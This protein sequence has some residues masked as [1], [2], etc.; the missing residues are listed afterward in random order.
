M[1]NSLWTSSVLSLV[2]VLP[3]AAQ[4]EIVGGCGDTEC[5]VDEV[6]ISTGYDHGTGSL[7]TPVAPD[8]WWTLVDAPN[9]GL[10]LPSPA[11]VITP[12]V[13]WTTFTG[14]R[15][16]S[17]YDT[18]ALNLDNPTPNAP[19]S[20]ERCICVCDP[21][22]LNINFDLL[23][24]NVADVYF[25]NVLIASQAGTGTGSFTTPLSVD[26]NR[27]V[28]AGEHCLR[29]DVRNLS[30]VAMGFSLEGSITTVPPGSPIMLSPLCCDHSGKLIV[31]KFA[32]LDCDGVKDPGD[33]PLKDWTFT[34]TPGGATATTDNNGCAYFTLAEGD[35]TVTETAQP[36]WVASVP[37]GGTQDVSVE[38]GSVNVLDF[39]NCPDQGKVTICKYQDAD[40]DGVMDASPQSLANWTFTITP[41]G[42]TVS[43]GGSGCKTVTLPSGTYTITEV[44]KAGWAATSPASG[45]A[46]VTVT[47]GSS[48]T[49]EFLNCANQGTLTICK[50][51]DTNCDGLV[52][53]PSK[54]LGSGW[55]FTI[56]PDNVTVTT[57]AGGCVSLLLAGGVYTVVETIQPSWTPKSPAT[58]SQSV[59]V[60]NGESTYIEFLNCPP[61]VCIDGGNDGGIYGQPFLYLESSLFTGTPA[62]L[63]LQDGPPFVAAAIL[64][65]TSSTPIP[66]HC[67]TLIAFPNPLLIFLATN[68]AGEIH[69]PFLWPAGLPSGLTIYMQCAIPDLTAPCKFSISNGVSATIP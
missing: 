52:D 15:W 38:T 28:L 14:A 10:T 22:T 32:D 49:V 13:A 51:I 68:P 23:V 53:S 63:S 24:D 42:Q 19:Y 6:I 20:F 44:P 37:V 58:G 30:G 27:T 21:V 29:V 41:G 46:T 34:V 8:G 17:A 65:S 35:Y 4:T 7:Y 69:L 18:S 60:V 9:T 54:V 26:V 25:D 57:G 36:Q 67:G 61:A 2:L 12:H 1:K 33:L 5:M 56:L 55:T 47:Q 48:Q 31:R 45:A 11:W 59:T 64:V 16:I 39:L 50:Y 62:E 66:F 40:C 3:L 43:T